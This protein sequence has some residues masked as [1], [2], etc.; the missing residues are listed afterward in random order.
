MDDDRAWHCTMGRHCMVLED[1]EDAADA[2]EDKEDEEVVAQAVRP[3]AHDT[4][5]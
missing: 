2:D 5:I 3:E 1:E 4:E